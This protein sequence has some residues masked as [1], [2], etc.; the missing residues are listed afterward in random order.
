MGGTALV[1][2]ATSGLGRALAAACARQ[3]MAL[4]LAGRTPERLAAVAADL[5]LRHGVPV[6]E[7]L[8]D[9]SDPQAPQRAADRLVALGLPDLL[10]FALGDNAAESA[11]GDPAEIARVHAVNFLCIAQLVG[12]LLPA[13][14]SRGSGALGVVGSVAGDRGR[15]GNFVYGSAKAALHVWA[16]GLRARLV[17]RGISVTWVKLGWVDTR[18]SYGLVPRRLAVSPERAARAVLRA[19][20]AGRAQAYV[21]GPWRLVM[22]LLRALPDALFRRL[23]I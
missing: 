6:E 14:E 15:R 9:G 8:F 22:L 2:G 1:V 11:P 5:R 17:P 12:L 16:E 10:L 18:L 19:V 23:P 20:R 7:L 3:G 21:P 4:Q 13:L